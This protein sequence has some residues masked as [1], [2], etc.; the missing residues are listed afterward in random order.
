[1][2]LCCLSVF[3]LELA[4]N[5]GKEGRVEWVEG[6]KPTVRSWHKNVSMRPTDVFCGQVVVFIG[7]WSNVALES[8][9]SDFGVETRMFV[10]RPLPDFSIK[11]AQT[12]T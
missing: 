12:S 9:A 4:L 10:V 11:C 2:S 6:V 5:A 7:G 8:T 3:S 1:M